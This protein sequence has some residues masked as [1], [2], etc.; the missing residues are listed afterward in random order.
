MSL[1]IDNVYICRLLNGEDVLAEV[2]HEDGFFIL[3]VPF[4]IM[5]APPSAPGALNIHMAPFPPLAKDSRVEIPMGGVVY[6]F[7]PEDKVLQKYSEI[8]NKVTSPLILPDTI[9]NPIV[10]PNLVK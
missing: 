8:Y 6:R 4:Q 1:N 3:N 2:T 7:K 10:A 5:M 9:N